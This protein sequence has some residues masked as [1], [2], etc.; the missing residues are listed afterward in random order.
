MLTAL[1]LAAPDCESA[2]AT[3]W[4]RIV[5]LGVL[6]AAASSLCSDSVSDKEQPLFFGAV[7]FHDPIPSYPHIIGVQFDPT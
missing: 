2:M 1:S 6:P 5:G 7:V 3:A 4:R